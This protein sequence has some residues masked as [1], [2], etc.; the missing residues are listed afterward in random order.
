V[1]ALPGDAN[2]QKAA[3]GIL[4]TL[5]KRT[6]PMRDEAMNAGRYESKPWALLHGFAI[7]ITTSRRGCQL[8]PYCVDMGLACFRIVAADVRRLT[9]R[10]GGGDFTKRFEPR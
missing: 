2:N 10:F 6:K 5:E 4:L 8:W 3:G 1:A 9:F 7:R